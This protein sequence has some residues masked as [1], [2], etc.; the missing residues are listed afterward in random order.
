MR[1]LIRSCP[2]SVSGVIVV[3]WKTCDKAG[4]VMIAVTMLSDREAHHQRV[5]R[6]MEQGVAGG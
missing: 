1:R 3:Q 2:M 6:I 4:R 5:V